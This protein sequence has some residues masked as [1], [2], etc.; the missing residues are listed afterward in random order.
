MATAKKNEEEDSRPCGDVLDGLD[1]T[2]DAEET[3]ADYDAE[4]TSE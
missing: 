3:A 4:E 2:T 1:D